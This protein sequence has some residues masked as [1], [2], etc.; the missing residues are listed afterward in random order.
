MYVFVSDMFVEDYVGGGELTTEAIISGTDLPVIKI[1]SS[2][3]DVGTIDALKDRHW[4]FGNYANMK[5]PIILHCCKNL[6]YSVIEYDYK[7]CSYR[8]PQKHID[9]EGSC[10]CE[11]S[12]HGKLV[13]VFMSNA[14]SL[15]F[16][17]HAQKDL[18]IEKFPFLNKRELLVLSSVFAEDTLDS[19]LSRNIENKNDTW[20]VQNSPSWVKG[21]K[22]AIKFAL[23]N[24]LK[25]ELFGGITHD[26]VLDKFSKYKGFIFLP[27]GFDTCPRTVIEAK[28]LGCELIMNDNV[29]H[30]DEP[31]FSGEKQEVIDYLRKRTSVFWNK[32][33]EYTRTP[34]CI[35]DDKEETHFKIIIP[36]YNAGPWIEKT[37]NSVKKQEYENYE[38][39][40]CDDISSDDTWRKIN[41]FYFPG[42]VK[43]KNTEKKFALKNIYEGVL[44]LNSKPEDVVVVLDGDDWFSNSHVL[45]NLNKLYTGTDCLLTYGSFVRY[46]DASIGQEASIYPKA[47]IEENSY[48]SDVWR[49]SHLKT[50]KC[51]LWE[52]VEEK[53][54]C[55]VNMRFYESSYDQAMM[56][57]MLEMAGPRAEYI[58]DIMYVYNVGNP[59]AVNKTKQQRQYNTMLEIRRKNKYKRL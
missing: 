31:W 26:E 45:S 38:C 21:T 59:N 24:N 15:W 48:R 37:L 39:L 20:L 56:L 47:V 51:S 43:V 27:K 18:Y 42:L 5:M 33:S 49:A 32:L 50:F 16:M 3:V 40:V 19:M 1:H 13:S 28:L 57:P 7:F 6:E 46:P 52:R 54:L 29:Q 34:K 10:N 9:A 36:S 41:D 58:P 12:N 44:Q 35:S 23:D 4:I 22:D 8:L 17:S 53:D 30:K 25:Y 14:K 11:S 55:D 2:R